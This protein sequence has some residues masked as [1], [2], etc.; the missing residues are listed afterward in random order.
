[1]KFEL[2]ENPQDVLLRNGFSF[3]GTSEYHLKKKIDSNKYFHAIV[4]YNYNIVDLHIDIPISGVT[5]KGYRHK[6]K[7]KGTEIF[8]EY[9]KIYFSTLQGK[10]DQIKNAIIGNLIQHLYNKF[11]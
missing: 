1:M 9:Q 7:T 5:N 8:R 10:L 11:N 6:T 4:E 2:E 3:R